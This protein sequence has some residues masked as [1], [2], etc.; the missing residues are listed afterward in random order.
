MSED[1]VSVAG[2]DG[3]KEWRFARGTCARAG[4]KVTSGGSCVMGFEISAERTGSDETRPARG[5][6]EEVFWRVHDDKISAVEGRGVLP[7]DEDEP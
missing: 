1:N 6:P 7:K 2:G 4:A 5:F 3:E